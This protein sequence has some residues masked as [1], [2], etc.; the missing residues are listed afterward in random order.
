MTRF[1]KKIEN[2]IELNALDQVAAAEGK[3][4]IGIGSSGSLYKWDRINRKA[5]KITPAEAM[6]ILAVEQELLDKIISTRGTY[7]IEEP[8]PEI[9]PEPV[10][11]TVDLSEVKEMINESRRLLKEARDQSEASHLDIYGKIDDLHL[12]I[13]D[14]LKKVNDAIADVAKDVAVIRKAIVLE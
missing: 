8:A 11:P 1:Y 4:A 12:A 9:A 5:V 6:A 13:L 7:I 10:V 2:T 3:Q 14:E